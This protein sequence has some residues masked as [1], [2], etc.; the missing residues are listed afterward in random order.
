MSFILGEDQINAINAI[1]SFIKPNKDIF[2]L[3]GSPKIT[4]NPIVNEIINFKT[5]ET[6]ITLSGFAGTGKSTI[7]KEIIN[8]LE[9]EYITYVLCAPTHVAKLVMEFFTEREAM[10]IHKLLS[11]SPNIEILNLDFKQLEFQ[12]KG[13]SN[14][15]PNN[16][17]VICDEA[18]M[19]NDD[20]YD[21]LLSR[22]KLV[23]S[24]VIFVGDAKQLQPVNTLTHSKVFNLP[25]T[26]TLNKIYRQSEESGLVNILP[27]LR[28]KIIPR[29][30]NSIGSDGSLLCYSD[31][32][33]FFKE[34]LPTFRKAINTS[35]ILET[36]VFTYTN[37][38]ARQYNYKI[39][40]FLFG[41]ENEY[42]KLQFLTCY[43]NF[44]WNGL[45][46]WN[47]MDYIVIDEPQKARIMIPHFAEMPG[48]KL[49]LYDSSTKISEEIFILSKEISKDYLNSLAY[50]IESKRI[51]AINTK[52]SDS[53]LSRK[54]WKEYYEIIESFTSPVDLFYDNRLIRK[55]T[56]DH[57]YASTVHKSQGRS[58]N[59]LFIDMKDIMICRNPDELRQLQ[60]VSVSRARHNVYIYQ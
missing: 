26:I 33:E 2:S 59:N 20:L 27:V 57:G 48:W 38:R 36:R 46:F 15:F 47:S 56:F 30:K 22:C 41:L 50:L 45:S 43:E 6:A 49:N 51:E 32:K 58:L 28:E 52:F 60:Y 1:K 25:N 31:I 44:K 16:G 53:R 5:R 24:L 11:L 10:T 14:L 42:D 39:K 17:V 12:S 54:L 3:S 40:E 7:V 35:D 29:F 23:N 37:D 34:L 55:K 9:Q 19:I 13:K 18:S 21:L 4:N 8:F